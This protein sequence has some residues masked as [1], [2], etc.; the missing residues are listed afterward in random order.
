MGPARVCAL[1]L[2]VL[3][4]LAPTSAHAAEPLVPVDLPIFGHE[5]KVGA[6]KV[7]LAAPIAPVAKTVDGAIADWVGKPSRYAGTSVYSGGEYVYQDHL[8]DAFGADAGEDVELNATLDPLAAAVP[9]TY[10]SEGI[11]RYLA[12]ELGLPPPF[13]ATVNYGNLEPAFGA[14]LEE[15]H[16]SLDASHVYV[17]A[18]TTKLTTANETGLLLLVDIGG[19]AVDR[20]VPFNSGLRSTRADLAV[21]VAGTSGRVADLRTGRVSPLG[22]GSVATD[23]TAFNNAIEARIPRA[24]LRLGAAAGTLRIAAGTGPFD[25]AKKAFADTGLP[26]NLANVAFRPAEPVRE[27]FE[28]QQAFSLYAKTIDPFFAHID[29]ARV[30]RAATERFVP[31]PGYY[32]RVFISKALSSE[33]SRDGIWQPYGIYLPTAFAER[34]RL[35]L[36][37]WL[38]WRGGTAHSAGTATPD[39]FRHLG[40]DQNTIVVSPRAR[41]TSSWYVGA[42]HADILEVYEQ[43]TRAY[44]IDLNR[45]YV[46]G[47]SM[48]GWGSYLFAVSHPDLFAAALPASPPQTQGAWTGLDFP[49]CDGLETEGYTPCYISDDDGRARDQAV[50][51]MVGNLRNLPVAVFT[52]MADELVPYLGV[53]RTSLTMTQLGYRNRLY[54]FATQEHYGP[55]VWDQWKDAAAYLHSFVRNPNPPRVTFRRDMLFERAVEEIRTQGAK[56]SF[57]LDR[58][59]WMSELTPANYVNAAATFDGRSLAIRQAPY[60]EV[61][62]VGGP[63]AI[64]NSGPYLMHGL[65]WLN[66]PTATAPAAVNGFQATLGG[67]KAVRLDLA[68][69]AIDSTRRV[70]GTVT[71]DRSMQLRLSGRWITAP[72][73][74]RNGVVVSRTLAAGVL[75]I[76]LPAGTSTLTIG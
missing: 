73:V 35:P 52:G 71:T 10:R 41:G 2:A 64:G 4:L 65:R 61:P 57:D 59:Y 19:G 5:L 36:Q 27:W 30:L 6:G 31:G 69:M 54:S 53:A 26:S 28:K 67:A 20:A 60:L 12:G 25:A 22:A 17:M 63:A 48:G 55:P 11:F 49:G 7:V 76:T 47:H 9:E 21:L 8:F 51:K 32:E 50:V 66:D 74:R 72:I 58:A 37:F 42:G 13:Q 56:L 46:A 68:R 40:E 16:V 34:K 24:A 15:L 1:L 23:P 33:G 75:S 14:D 38:H 3:G 70:T 45:V 18:R 29:I 43:V 44:A 39:I 62:E